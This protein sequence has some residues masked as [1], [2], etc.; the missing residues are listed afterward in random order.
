MFKA[1]GRLI[2]KK[3]FL[4]YARLNDRYEIIDICAHLSRSATALVMLPDRSDHFLPALALLS[5]LRGRFPRTSFCILANE[6]LLRNHAPQLAADEDLEIMPCT[7]KDLSFGGLPKPSLREAIRSRHLDLLIDLNDEF[8]LAAA[9]L[10]RCSDAKLR[11]CLQHPHRDS[12][13]NF[14]IG[15]H[16]DES[17]E[18]KYETL[19]KY[20][21]VFLPVPGAA[22]ADLLTA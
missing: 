18:R 2:T 9:Y 12:F 5:H 20:I 22:P 6:S 8:N 10:C 21:S 15:V 3:V 7:E 13:Y 11:I 14:Q 1:L 16:A 17:A 19:I 4:L